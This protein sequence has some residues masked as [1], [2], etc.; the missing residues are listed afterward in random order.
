MFL[1]AFLA[2]RLTN[3]GKGD[4][5]NRFDEARLDSLM[6]QYRARGHDVAIP[7][8][9]CRQRKALCHPA[10]QGQLAEESPDLGDDV[11]DASS[12]TCG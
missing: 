12:E 8:D 5:P 10:G 6:E 11:V 9:C 7:A 4:Q 1:L 3:S 2:R